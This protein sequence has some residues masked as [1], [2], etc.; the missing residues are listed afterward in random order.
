MRF[1]VRFENAG[2]PKETM[3]ASIRALGRSLGAEARSPKWTSYGALEVD[4]FCA[5][6]ADFELFLTALGP[7]FKTEFV[8]DL[9]KA[10]AHQSEDQLFAESRDYFN[11]ERYWECHEVLEAVWKAKQG[12]EKCLLQGIILVCAAF[13]HHQKGE[14][15]V[16]L[17]V[18][19]RAAKQLEFNSPS[20]AGIDLESLRENV[21][22]LLDRKQLSNF[23]V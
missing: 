10:P 14:N 15:G 12:D 1:L 18:L 22:K 8:H 4:I 9:N 16:A 17:S 7:L 21:R 20:Y 23:L 13:V 3:L 11:A 6:V 19:G 2:L 5:T